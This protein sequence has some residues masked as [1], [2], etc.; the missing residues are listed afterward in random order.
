MSRG[1]PEKKLGRLPDVEFHMSTRRRASAGQRPKTPESTPPPTKPLSSTDSSPLSSP[2]TSL[3]STP[4]SKSAP[5]KQRSRRPPKKRKVN[6]NQS[7]DDYLQATGATP[8]KRAKVTSDVSQ[9]STDDDKSLIREPPKRPP[10]HTFYGAD[11]KTRYR[12][13]EQPTDSAPSSPPKA[14][15][16]GGRGR[17]RGGRFANG[18]G[19]GRGK[20]RE[21]GDR[22][23]TPEPPTKKHVLTEE[24]RGMLTSLKARQQEL[25]KFFQVVGTQQNDVLDL[26]A[27]RDIAKLVKK[28]RAHKKA[29]EF[30]ETTKELEEVMEQ[31]R[32]L[33]R[34]KYD[35][36]VEA[37]EKQYQM[38]KES[39][40]KRY[41]VSRHVK[42]IL[43]VAD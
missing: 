5:P 27:S 22:D 38:E 41:T 40:E 30:E 37:A 31:E 17:G 25:K 23:D 16:G 10:P 28:P 14:L 19:R 6:F 26:I 1:P 12:P 39:I 32:D 33:F 20:T 7:T 24:E 15:R 2:P 13:S 43:P 11:A 3:G 4:K 35:M 9:D 42:N 29:S 36:H 18:G 21:H 8:R 34:L